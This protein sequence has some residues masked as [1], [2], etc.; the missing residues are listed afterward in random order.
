MRLT[1]NRLSDVVAGWKGQPPVW[2][3]ELKKMGVSDVAFFSQLIGLSVYDNKGTRL[4]RLEDLI[5]KPGERF[6]DVSSIVFST[7][8]QRH[9]IVPW[10]QV[11]EVGGRIRLALP[12]ERIPPGEKESAD[13][14][15]K[16][17]V[18]DKQIVDTSGLKVVRVND[19]LL[20]RFNNVLSVI[21]VDTGMKS[22]LRRLGILGF[23][24][25]FG[26]DLQDHVIPWSYMQPLQPELLS[27][28]LKIPRH[29][30]SELHPADIADIVEELNNRQRVALLKSMDDEVA[31]ETLEESD[32][33]VQVKVAG[34]MNKVRMAHILENMSPEEA[35]DLLGMLPEEKS[36]E[37]LSLMNREEAQEV[38][39]L[40]KY[41]VRS[42]GGMMTPDYVTVGV[43][44]TVGD[45]VE[46]VRKLSEEVWSVYYIYVVDKE[47]R[48][49]GYISM[50][51]LLLARRTESVT[52]IMSEE[53]AKVTVD[54]PIEEIA[55]VMAKYDLLA[56]P[57]VDD[58]DSLLGVVI[59]DDVIDLV[60]PPQWK[61]QFP[62]TFPRRAKA[63]EA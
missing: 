38:S 49:Q 59:V 23:V 29:G 21:G 10:H 31:A 15:L 44:R 27:L 30:I 16:D 17:T 60:V 56:V 43:D 2:A 51:D 46:E 22:L 25:R 58:K 55:S 41:P 61:Q 20:A 9:Y 63:A 18:L 62:R 1:V 11:E 53:T 40:L 39:G 13:L 26:A 4:G 14:S 3:E 42:A 33:D 24:G 34:C 50:K 54:K 35:A 7:F 28:H 12:R 45:A 6:L 47:N 36:A 32:I 57:V 5:V 19:V 48:L 52:G 37:L 8:P